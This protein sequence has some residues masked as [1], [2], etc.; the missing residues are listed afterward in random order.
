M[1]EARRVFLSFL[2]SFLPVGEA[3]ELFLF[4]NTGK[5]FLPQE[6]SLVDDVE[7]CGWRIAL[8]DPVLLTLLDVTSPML[9][10]APTAPWS[11]DVLGLNSGVEV[12]VTLGNIGVSRSAALSTALPVLVTLL[13]LVPPMLEQAPTASW[14]RGTLGL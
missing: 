4:E 14:S 6:S 13:G 8:N 2:V 1:T 11:R 7:L 10:Q 5:N 9:E 12:V 3:K